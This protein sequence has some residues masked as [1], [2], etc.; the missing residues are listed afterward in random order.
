MEPLWPTRSVKPRTRRRLLAIEPTSEA[1]TI[2]VRPPDTAMIAMI[3]SGALPNVA[4]RKPPIPGP[5]WRARLSVASP[6]SQE[7]GISAEPIQNHDEWC[8]QQQRQERTASDVPTG[9]AH[10]L[11]LLGDARSPAFSRCRRDR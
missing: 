10:T 7:R 11:T 5:V 3:S 8:Q 1:L 2:A 9:P 4:F 6:M